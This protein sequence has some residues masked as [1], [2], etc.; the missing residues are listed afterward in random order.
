M[1]H[2]LNFKLLYVHVYHKHGCSHVF[3]SL[4]HAN[5]YVPQTYPLRIL[6]SIT[7][8]GMWQQFVPLTNFIRIAASYKTIHLFNVS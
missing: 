2:G 8:T 7:S 5:R 1:I 6:F 4:R 3:F